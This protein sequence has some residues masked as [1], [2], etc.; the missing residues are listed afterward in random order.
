MVRAVALRATVGLQAPGTKHIWQPGSCLR[1]SPGTP[2]LGGVRFSA[3]RIGR[4]TVPHPELVDVGC[5]CPV[6][7]SD[8][9]WQ[10]PSHRSCGTIRAGWQTLLSPLTALSASP[11]QPWTHRSLRE[12]CN[13]P[14]DVGS[15]VPGLRRHSWEG[16]RWARI[17][18]T[19]LDRLQLPAAAVC[20]FIGALGRV[21]GKGH[22][23]PSGDV[24][25]RRGR[26]VWPVMPCCPCRR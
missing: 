24:C 10:V 23:A 5:L 2:W 11:G 8:R 25:M 13:L 21:D 18:T 4:P 19:A 6:Q 3:G 12:R 14:G 26:R 15:F 22:F 16:T 7:P 9:R 17:P 1:C 20:L